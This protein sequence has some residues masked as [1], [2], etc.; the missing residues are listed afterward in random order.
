MFGEIL[1]AQLILSTNSRYDC[2]CLR[3]V[4]F[5][6]YIVCCEICEK[7]R[8][9]VTW[10]IFTIHGKCPSLVGIQKLIYD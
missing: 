7:A 9:F 3:N 8:E 6:T 2:F 1:K 10:I 5:N 4:V